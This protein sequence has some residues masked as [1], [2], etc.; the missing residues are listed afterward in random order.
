M[1]TAMLFFIAI[2]F[3]IAPSFVAQFPGTLWFFPAAMAFAAFLWW[4]YWLGESIRPER[5]C[6]RGPGRRASR[7][8]PSPPGQPGGRA[9]QQRFSL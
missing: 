8:F 6:S 5:A 3:A 9:V 1:I 2:A 4:L 7:D